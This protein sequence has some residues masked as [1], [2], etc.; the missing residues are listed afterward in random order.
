M[1]LY[2]IF[3]AGVGVVASKKQAND[4][5][6]SMS[7]TKDVR[8]GEI[9][10]QLK[11][12]SLAEAQEPNYDAVLVELCELIIKNKRKNNNNG[13]VAAAVIGNGKKV[14]A[15]SHFEGK[16]AHAERC[17]LD[18]YKSMYGEIPEDAV[19]VT[20]LSPCVDDMPDR[21][22]ISCNELIETTPVKMVYCGYRDPEHQ[23]V[24]HNDFDIRFTTNP[25]IENLCKQFADMFQK[26]NL[27]ESQEK[28]NQAIDE[29]VQ[30]AAKRLGI[31][32]LPD[33]Q[34]KD[35]IGTSEH[36][37]FG[38]FDPD[39]NSVQV[40]IGG[41]HVMDVLRTLAHELV[42]H[43]QRELDMIQPGDGATGSK[44]ENQA[45]AVA[46]V[47]MRDFADQ[48][49]GFFGA[50][51]E[52]KDPPEQKK[53]WDDYGQPAVPKLEPKEKVYKN[54][55]H[56]DDENPKD[57]SQQDVKEAFDQPYPIK[58]EKSEYGDYDALAKLPNGSNLSIM[59]E[60]V[61]PY[62][63]A[64]EFW[65][66]NSVN[67]TGEGDSQRIFATVLAAI[68]EFLKIEQPANISFSASKEVEPGQNSESRAKL[69]NRLVQRYATS[70]G[71][72]AMSFDHGEEIKYELTSNRPVDENFAD[73]KHP[74]RKG[75]SKRMG[76]DTHASVS[77]LRNTAKHSS[78]E[79]QRM[80]HWLANMKAGRAKHNK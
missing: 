19:I 52:L 50:L 38:L 40:A 26:H 46:G 17:A 22:G 77:S 2:D 60:H 56:Y 53:S 4:P 31:K 75:L 72:K 59:F 47:L 35:A 51:N 9:E 42:H 39:T 64:I 18:K 66:N 16:R 1:N 55:Q 54:W 76:V 78:G 36:P 45:N 28:T 24:E 73:G 43:K 12:Y 57:K 14:C 34:I 79:K 70:W 63:V 80:A 8:P 44:I 11:K 25:E 65:R 21:Q 62:E 48:H 15:T 61:T 6:Y 5:R 29:M 69:Y 58:W 41:R 23:E 33:I 27:H 68:Q 30:Y 3:E 7:L 13:L 10:R 74:G 67:V 32:Q 20:T 71:Y 37:T 49:P